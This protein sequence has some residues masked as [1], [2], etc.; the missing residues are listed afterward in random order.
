M[1]K[2]CNNCN[3]IL[4][5]HDVNE[6]IEN[7]KYDFFNHINYYEKKS[8]VDLNTFLDFMNNK[9][10]LII[11]NFGSLIKQQFD[12]G[13][14][15]KIYPDC[16][17]KSIQYLENGYTFFNNG[18]DNNF[19]DTTNVICEQIKQFDNFDGVIISAGAYS[20]LIAEYVLNTL[21]KKVYTIGRDLIEYCYIRTQDNFN[22]NPLYISIPED[23]KPNDYKKIENQDK[24]VGIF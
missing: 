23:L 4:Y 9:N 21:N 6:S 22:E 18:P 14:F 17:I 11:N 24:N 1:F 2:T 13:N 20:C 12:N 15:K 3:I 8:N 10:I 16:N 19:L 5:F 7:H